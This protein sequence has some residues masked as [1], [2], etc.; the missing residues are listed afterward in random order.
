MGK[1]GLSSGNHAAQVQAGRINIG[2]QRVGGEK[3]VC[4]RVC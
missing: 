4:V 1:L 2:E 3:K